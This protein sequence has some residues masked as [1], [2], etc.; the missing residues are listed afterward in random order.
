MTH[1]KMQNQL[2]RCDKLASIGRLSAGGAHEIMNP[3]N[4]I[5]LQLGILADG[6]VEASD[7]AEA[8]EMMG[9]QV[10]RITKIA[11][12]LRRFSRLEELEI[13]SLGV[14]DLLLEVL[15][16]SKAELSRGTLSL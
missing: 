7:L 12:G 2:I 16:L 15:E 1:K 5:N 13:I 11:N 9:K 4:V 8:L 3:L 6:E 14:N 10:K